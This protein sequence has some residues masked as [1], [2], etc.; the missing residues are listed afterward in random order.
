[1][2]VDSSLSGEVAALQRNFASFLQSY[3]FLVSQGV[4]P[5]DLLPANRAELA[6][7]IDARLSLT[8]NTENSYK[9]LFN[10]NPI[11]MWIYDRTT[12]RFLDVNEAAVS[13]YGYD[14]TEF[15]RMTILDIRSSSEAEKLITLG[16]RVDKDEHVSG[17]HWKHKR[18]NGDIID[19]EITAKPIRYKGIQAALVIATDITE[20]KT[21]QSRLESINRKLNTAKQIAKMGYWEYSVTNQKWFWSDQIYRILGWEKM[22]KVPNYE[23]FLAMVHPEDRDYYLQKEKE[24]WETGASVDAAYRLILKDGTVKYVLGRYSVIYDEDRKEVGLEGILQ[25]ITEQKNAEEELKQRNQQLKELSRHLQHVREEE[26]RHLSREVHDELGQLASAVK[27]DIDWLYLHTA[28]TEEKIRKR[29][30]QASKISE[31]MISTIRKIASDLRPGMLDELGLNAS[32][33][34][35]CNE[36]SRLNDIPCDFYSNVDEERLS[37]AVKTELYRICQEALSNVQFHAQASK[38]TVTLTERNDDTIRLLVIDNG[39]GFDPSIRTASLG[40]VGMK[41]RCIAI[42]GK[43]AITSKPG[44]GTTISVTIRKKNPNP[45]IN[46]S[47]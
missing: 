42:D 13:Q 28:T 35:K 40:L 38:V 8:G 43:L 15:L 21:V 36:F 45:K 1:M 11:P 10:F 26:R 12:L 5:G 14:H 2:H 37:P 30:A 7:E 46:S 9:E 19:V 44:Y 6:G 29:T 32:L 3:E 17:A 24:T 34:W 20:R 39:K 23:M 22:L 31:L 18:C 47:S 41:E 4:S 16:G 27:M 25:D 33:E